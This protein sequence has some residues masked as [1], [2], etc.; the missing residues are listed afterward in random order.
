[1]QLLEDVVKPDA[2]LSLT[3]SDVVGMPE[4]DPPFASILGRVLYHSMLRIYHVNG[5]GKYCT[6]S[7][8]FDLLYAKIRQF[9][10]KKEHTS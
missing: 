7:L 1:M 10:G 2:L 3:L 6:D 9:S 4:D 8:H 5:L